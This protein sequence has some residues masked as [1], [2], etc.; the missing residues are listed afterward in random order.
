[1]W[2][3]LNAKD[4]R[5][6]VDA[7]ES[8][9][10]IGAP[11]SRREGACEIG[12]PSLHELKTLPSVSRGAVTGNPCLRTAKSLLQRQCERQ[13]RLEE[14]LEGMQTEIHAA[15]ALA[16]EERRAT[17]LCVSTDRK[18]VL[19]G[20]NDGGISIWNAEAGRMKEISLDDRNSR[21]RSVA[22]SNDKQ[23]VVSGSSDSTI[24][25]WNATTGRQ[26][27]DALRGHDGWVGAMAI[28]HGCQWFTS[29]SQDET[30]RIW[31]LPSGKAIGKPLL[32]HTDRIRCLAISSDD[33]FVVSGSN[34]ETAR[35]WDVRSGET[36]VGP[37][38]HGAWVKSIYVSRDNQEIISMDVGNRVRLWS[39]STGEQ[40]KFATNVSDCARLL[41]KAKNGWSGGEKAGAESSKEKVLIAVFDQ[42]VYICDPTRDQNSFEKVGQF[43]AV[44]T[45]W[46]VDANGVLWVRFWDGKL[47]RLEMVMGSSN[48][49]VDRENDASR[50]GAT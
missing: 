7:I 41:W 22:I 43:D 29:A 37:F 34:D 4:L 21:V 42:D 16:P 17:T 20:Y 44:A 15:P 11:S 27:G 12:L 24:C 10:R 33:R 35:I 18:V 45:D 5:S 2:N 13:H 32:G 36:V 40:L 28:S 26:V 46:G 14:I 3:R 6:G 8:D 30:I 9:V 25:I 1:M 19:A 38:K 23:H 48:A 50:C 31:E 47:A 39:V 49:F